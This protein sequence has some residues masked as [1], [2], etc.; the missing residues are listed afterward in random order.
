MKALDDPEA[1][2]Y[3]GVDFWLQLAKNPSETSDEGF[4]EVTGEVG[5]VFLLHPF[6]LHSA[7]KN[8]LRR[9][10]IITNPPVQLKE[11]FCFDREDKTQY[12]LV[13]L[14]TL[15]DLGKPDGLR[16]WKITGRRAEWTPR[17]IKRMEEM[18]QKE[19]ERLQR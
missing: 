3:E 14:K 12:S 18:K 5:D 15:M 1:G 16:G 19:L 9:P 8:L 10:R 13:E 17:R 4:F 11:P 6:M 2:T 7:S